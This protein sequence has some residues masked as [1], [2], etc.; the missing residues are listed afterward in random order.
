MKRLFL[1]FLGQLIS[2]SNAQFSSTFVSSD[3]TIRPMGSGS[4]MCA[5]KR[6]NSYTMGQDVWLWPCDPN[7]GSRKYLWEYDEQTGLVK[8]LGSLKKE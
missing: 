4:E 6:W 2:F 7:H 5:Y 3:Q 1:P 8:S